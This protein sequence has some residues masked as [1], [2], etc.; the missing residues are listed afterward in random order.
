[1]LTIYDYKF[2]DEI[3]AKE[4]D[5]SGMAIASTGDDKPRKYIVLKDDD[6]KEIALIEVD[7]GVINYIV[8]AFIDSHIDDLKWNIKGFFQKLKNK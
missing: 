8:R 2:T 1:M 5:W 7:S 3:K 6:G 4:I